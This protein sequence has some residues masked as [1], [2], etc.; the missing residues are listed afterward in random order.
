M[1]T[2]TKPTNPKDRIAGSKLSMGLVPDVARIALALAFT[3]GAVKY[4]RFNWRVAGVRASVYR[5]AMERHM[6]KWWNGQDK[7]PATTVHHLA[8]MMACC[9]IILDAELYGMLNDDR[10]PAPNRDAMANA[11]DGA[12][13]TTRFLKNLFGSFNPHQPTLHEPVPP[14]VLDAAADEMI[15]QI[16]GD[17]VPAGTVATAAAKRKRKR[18]TIPRLAPMVKRKARK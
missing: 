4:G 13:A 11:V 14:A 10:P 6:V 5:D 1:S 3:E 12:E 7:D 8:N 15:R 18:K 16:T 17:N 2:D 9:A